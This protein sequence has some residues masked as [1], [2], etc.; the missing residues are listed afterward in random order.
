LQEEYKRGMVIKGQ[1]YERFFMID[2]KIV[3]EVKKRLVTV[4][5][6]ITIYLFGSYAWGNPTPDSDLDLLVVVET[7][8]EKRYK[9]SIPGTHALIGLMI[10]HDLLILTKEEFSNKSEDVS[11][12]C[13][14]I[15]KEGKVLYVQS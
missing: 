10:P 12:L 7:S 4:Y 2:S 5:K 11:T 8:G 9:R 1:N 15:K 14:K 6:P 3:E 13:Y